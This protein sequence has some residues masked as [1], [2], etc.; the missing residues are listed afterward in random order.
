MGPRA[1]RTL[2]SEAL[3]SARNWMPEAAPRKTSTRVGFSGSRVMPTCRDAVAETPARRLAEASRSTSRSMAAATTALLIF[4]L[5]SDASCR[6]KVAVVVELA[7]YSR[8]RRS[9]TADGQS[10]VPAVDSANSS[11]HDPVQ[12]RV[13]SAG[14]AARPSAASSESSTAARRPAGSAAAASS[15]SMRAMKPAKRSSSE[16][17]VYGTSVFKVSPLRVSCKYW[18]SACRACAMSSGDTLE[19]ENLSNGPVSV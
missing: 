7:V 11:R 19:R 17:P 14:V 8:L 4:S 1:A 10:A 9:V 5:R 15:S 18:A 16:M 6:L 12:P 13:T 2:S 3:T